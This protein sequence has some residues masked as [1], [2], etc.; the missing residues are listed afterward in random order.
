VPSALLEER[1]VNELR[2]RGLLS[3]KKRSFPLSWMVGSVAA[4]VALFA[5]GIVVGQWMGTRN[6]INTVA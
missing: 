4:S 6:T 2:S 5:T 3:H 1:T